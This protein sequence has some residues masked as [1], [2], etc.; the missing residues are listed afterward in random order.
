MVY[1]IIK[2][3]SIKALL[4]LLVLASLLTVAVSFT[5]GS[6]V[7]LGLPTL[8]SMPINSVGTLENKVAIAISVDGDSD[9]I[10]DTL[11][12]LSD[13]EIP[14]TMFVSSTWAETNTD[15]MDGIVASGVEVGLKSDDLSISKMHADKAANLMQE[16]IT[17]LNSLV[18][19]NI[20]LYD[21]VSSGFNKSFLNTVSSLGLQAI[22]NDIDYTSVDDAQ[23]IASTTMK[24]ARDGSIVSLNMADNNIV[25]TL[26]LVI[27]GLVSKGY[28]L[29][30][31]GDL[32][33]DSDYTIDSDGRQWAV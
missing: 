31:V 20:K 16:W 23:S 22:G 24:Q 29:V 17:T 27:T 5:Q 15:S 7:M 10:N 32:V 13:Y 11:K 1:V 21:A 33:L 8:K 6:A 14:V 12:V 3:N 30:P 28:E 25:E 4:A 2:K 9:S 19:Q 18:D 26:P